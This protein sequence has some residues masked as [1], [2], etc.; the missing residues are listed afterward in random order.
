MAEFEV[1][2]QDYKL[3][4]SH[5]ADDGYA[6]ITIDIDNLVKTYSDLNEEADLKRLRSATI[7]YVCGTWKSSPRPDSAQWRKDVE[8]ICELIKGMHKLEEVT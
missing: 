1:L 2:L 7:L 8:M 5:A 6:C 4:P 3:E